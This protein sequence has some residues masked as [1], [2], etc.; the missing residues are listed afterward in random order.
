MLIFTTDHI[1]ALKRHPETGRWWELDGAGPRVVV[2]T[3]A[4]FDAKEVFGAILIRGSIS[5]VEEDEVGP[6]G[7]QEY[8]QLSE[9]ED[10]SRGALSSS[11]HQSASFAKDPFD[12]EPSNATKAD[13]D[14]GKKKLMKKKKPD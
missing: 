13:V 5:L 2:D 6:G 7:Q 3:E 4:L 1:W 11:L 8:Q 9:S 14:D 12:A 10:I